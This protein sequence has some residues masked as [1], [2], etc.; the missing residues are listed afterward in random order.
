[1]KKI[2]VSA[3]LTMLPIAFLTIVSL[4]IMTQAGLASS[5]RGL[6]IAK[7]TALRD[8]GFGDFTVEGQML[9]KNKAGKESVRKFITT[10]LEIPNL[11]EGDKSV[12]VF[13]EPRDVK[14]TALL[15]HTK[16]EPE[17]DSQWI[18]LPAIKRTKR[19]SSSNRTGKF[20]SSEFSY[21]DLGS[22]E[23]EDNE[24]IWLAD[25]P[26][27]TDESLTC[28]QV[29]SRP[30]NARSGY[31]KRVSYTDLD[32]YRVHKIEFY[33]RRGDLEKV[34]IFEDYSQYLG[35]YWRSH[36]MIM[37][38]I[39]TGKSTKLNWGEYSF[40]KGLTEQ[41]FTPQALERSSR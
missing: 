37:E 20:V 8:D 17:D 22:E 33:N 5:E 6:E 26:C 13:S 3:P 39:Q 11:S 10:T 41:D 29:E 28:A 36:K 15:T 4:I 34:L 19:I 14:G 12:I 2:S 38:N 35:Q 30:K 18:F 9:L 27:P 7:E 31:S 16:I 40:R 21:E 1:M 32:E 23:V 25:M 24:H